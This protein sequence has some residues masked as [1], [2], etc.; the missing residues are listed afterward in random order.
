M[1]EIS[2]RDAPH[3]HDRGSHYQLFITSRKND[4]REHIPSLA[5]TT[6]KIC[7]WQQESS[8]SHHCIYN[9]V[10]AMVYCIYNQLYCIYNQWCDC[11]TP[12]LKKKTLDANLPSSFRPISNLTTFSKLIE[13]LVQTRLQPHITSSPNFP[14]NQS[15]YRPLQSS[16]NRDCDGPHRQWPDRCV[17]V[18]HTNATLDLTSAFDTVDHT[19]LVERLHFDFGVA[20]PALDWLASYL[21][22]RHQFC[23][24]R[25]VLGSD[26]CV[27]MRSDTGLCSPA[28]TLRCVHFTSIDTDQKFWRP[29]PRLC[30][31]YHSLC[32]RRLGLPRHANKPAAV[33]RCCQRL[34]H[35]QRL[36]RE[37]F[38]IRGHTFWHLITAGKTSG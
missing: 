28:A 18:R 27:L 8:T 3:F 6:F 29:R 12:L 13:R 10:Y 24:G 21:A 1:T 36:A 33:R 7:C 16:F 19:K 20:G 11:I 37:R 22:N 9:L 32:P 23:H 14:P 25:I 34:V 35:A 15:A 4:K 38:K 2:S 5:V 26:Y 31:R 17:R 30:R